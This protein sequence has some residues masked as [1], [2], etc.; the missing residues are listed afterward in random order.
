MSLLYEARPISKPQPVM[1]LLGGS[2]MTP[3]PWVLYFKHGEGPPGM[4]AHRGSP[5]RERGHGK[6]KL[7][8]LGSAPHLP[9]G[10][11]GLRG[12]GD[13]SRGN[14]LLDKEPL[15]SPWQETRPGLNKK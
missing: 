2:L 1:S 9:Q 10:S 4:E 3:N 11:P 5:E 8:A 7:E 6:E 12:P 13:H 15:R 14:L